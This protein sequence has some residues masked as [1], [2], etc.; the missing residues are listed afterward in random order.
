[1]L[2]VSTPTLGRIRIGNTG[3]GLT[4]LVQT[5]GFNLSS[6]AEFEGSN[7]T[8]INSAACTRRI[9]GPNTI[10]WF[11]SLGDDP[12]NGT[13]TYNLSD[14]GS[15]ILNGTAIGAAGSKGLFVGY[16]ENGVFNQNGGTVAVGT[17]TTP[18]PLFIGNDGQ[19][20]G[21]GTGVGTY[22]L[23]DGLLT[24]IGTESIGNFGTGTFIQS[25]GTHVTDLIQVA[26]VNGS[27]GN[28]R[29]T[30]GH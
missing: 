6:V 17:A 19:G 22:N 13:G 7:A 2:D 11:L 9:A 8:G 3:T 10:T 16:N 1:M 25:G 30:G 28:Y 26:A 12:G 18:V 27:V 4:T 29:L 14:S 20:T 23:S 21:T 24:V 5:D 15:V